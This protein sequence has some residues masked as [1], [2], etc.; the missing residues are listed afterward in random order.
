[1]EYEE[2][3]QQQLSYKLRAEKS[4][5]SVILLGKWSPRMDVIALALKDNSVRP[6]VGVA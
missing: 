5:G 3:E 4:L 2:E 1:M 6:A